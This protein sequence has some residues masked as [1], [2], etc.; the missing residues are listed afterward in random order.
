ML[1]MVITEFVPRE[2]R[3]V[4]VVRAQPQRRESRVP[5]VRMHDVRAE[6]HAPA[7]F[8]R[9]ARQHQEAPMFVGVA[10]VELRARVQRV[11]LDQVHRRG[12]TRQSRAPD[13][14]AVLVAAGQDAQALQRLD[15]RGV[16]ACRA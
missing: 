10:G 15:P 4:L 12:R 5:V 1:W 8:E 16:R 9:G 6:I 2:H 11:R 13:V 7:T 3:V 14:D